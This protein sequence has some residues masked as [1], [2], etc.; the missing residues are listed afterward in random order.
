MNISV[1]SGKGGTG[2]TFISTNLAY[3]VKNALYIDCDV[4][5]PNGWLFLNPKIEQQEKVA[6]MVPSVDSE[7]CSGCR[8]CVDFCKFNAIAYI[9]NKLMVFNEL[10]HACAGCVML[11][12]ETALTES[13]RIIGQ[14]EYGTSGSIKTRTGILNTGEATG[15]PIIRSL[16]KNIP[17]KENVII[18]CP[19]GSSCTVMESI[20]DSD[21]CVLVAEPTLFGVHNLSTVFELVKLFNKPY[22]VVLNKAVKGE[23]VADNFCRENGIPILARITYEPCIGFMNSK[24][25]IA[26]TQNVTYYNLFENLLGKINKEVPAQNEATGCVKR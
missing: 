16:L 10:C 12:P 4:E 22:G 25:M 26:V 7:K 23:T 3:V 20:K 5:E 21:F 13:G 9:K 15:V 6:V 8:K 2:K 24:G 11:C 17:D 19:P 1:L 18:D 14:I